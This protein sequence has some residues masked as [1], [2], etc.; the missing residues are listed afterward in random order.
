VKP[1]PLNDT[2]KT[3]STKKQARIYDRLEILGEN[4]NQYD[5]IEIQVK[6]FNQGDHFG[7]FLLKKE[8]KHSLKSHFLKCLTDCVCTVLN[9]SDFIRLLGYILFYWSLEENE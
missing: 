4:Q 5:K 1:L 2:P 3:I 7:E 9:E 6:I 8:T